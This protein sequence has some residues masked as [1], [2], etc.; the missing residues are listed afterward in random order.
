MFYIGKRTLFLILH[1]N[2]EKVTSSILIALG[3][4]FNLCVL[5]LH[6]RL[7][8][9][10]Y[11]N[12]GRWRT[13]FYGNFL[14]NVFSV[15]KM[16]EFFIVQT[17]LISLWCNAVQLGKSA[18]PCQSFFCFDLWNKDF[19]SVDKKCAF[20]H[21]LM[22]T[23]AVSKW[24]WILKLYSNM[25]LILMIVQLPFYLSVGPRKMIVR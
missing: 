23:A 4:V 7:H 16:S 25:N 5:E 2:T 22:F 9:K 10:I 8:S 6:S 21:S 3:N 18:A 13:W 15:V 20:C 12:V 17:C 24:L 1:F 14:W 19:S 11:Q